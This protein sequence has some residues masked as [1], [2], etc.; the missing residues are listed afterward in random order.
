MASTAREAS[1]PDAPVKRTASA[2]IAGQ[3]TPNAKRRP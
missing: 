2:L 3:T 1:Y